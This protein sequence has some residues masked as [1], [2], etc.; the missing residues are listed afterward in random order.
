MLMAIADNPV[1]S[2]ANHGSVLPPSWRTLYELTKLPAPKLVALTVQSLA[3][4]AVDVRKQYMH[5]AGYGLPSSALALLRCN[6]CCTC[7]FARMAD[8]PIGHTR[9]PQVRGPNGVFSTGHQCPVACGRTQKQLLICTR[10]RPLPA[11]TISSGSTVAANV[12]HGQFLTA[13]VF[14]LSRAKGVRAARRAKARVLEK[15]PLVA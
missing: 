10:P 1:L 9:Y 12:A 8:Y 11:W 13:P 3:R 7:L 6:I 2:K 4:K 5:I 14:G 15:Y